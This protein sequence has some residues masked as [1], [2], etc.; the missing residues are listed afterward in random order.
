MY[1]NRQFGRIIDPVL[2][3]ATTLY[4]ILMSNHPQWT[5]NHQLPAWYK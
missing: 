2:A 5:I 1:N 3:S 4:D